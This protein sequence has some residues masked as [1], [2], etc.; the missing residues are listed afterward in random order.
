[1]SNHG[2][3]LRLLD[4]ADQGNCPDGH[5]CY[6]IE[7]S[8]QGIDRW[9]RVCFGPDAYKGDPLIRWGTTKADVDYAESQGADS[10]LIHTARAWLADRE[11]VADVHRPEPVYGEVVT[12]LIEAL[13]DRGHDPDRLLQALDNF[14]EG[15]WWEAVGGQLIDDF[16]QDWLGITPWPMCPTNLC[17][18]PLDGSPPH[19]AHPGTL[20][21]D[22]Y[23]RCLEGERL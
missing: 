9:V 21:A 2:Q 1:M 17:S 7:R 14:S 19:A 16:A 18:H 3:E 23:C 4:V 13:T 5:R 22:P 20:C 6:L 12:S 8:Q 15:D 10:T 11:P